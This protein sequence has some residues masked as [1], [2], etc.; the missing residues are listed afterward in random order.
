[1]HRYFYN[2]Y[3]PCSHLFS[4]QI[5]GSKIRKTIPELEPRYGI[6]P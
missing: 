6:E 3:D 4:H 2:F 5:M 1:M